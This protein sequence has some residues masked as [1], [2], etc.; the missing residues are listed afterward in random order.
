MSDVE[1][2]C[3]GEHGRCGE[4]TLNDNQ[5]CRD[6]DISQSLDRMLCTGCNRM[7]YATDVAPGLGEYLW[8]DRCQCPEPRPPTRWQ[9][10]YGATP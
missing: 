1:R 7:R 3:L 2:P 10:D 5:L 6:C 8:G 9:R 4:T